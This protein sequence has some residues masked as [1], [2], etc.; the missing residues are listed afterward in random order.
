VS[1]LRLVVALQVITVALIVAGVV[2]AWVIGL[3][4]PLYE[5]M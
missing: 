4:G 3:T 1:P 2:A 5:H